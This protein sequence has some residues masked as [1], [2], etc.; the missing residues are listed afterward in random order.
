MAVIL[1]TLFKVGNNVFD[2]YYR[3]RFHILHTS[4][5][6]LYCCYFFLKNQR[7]YSW[8]G[9]F[10]NKSSKSIKID[11]LSLMEISLYCMLHNCTKQH[12]LER[13]HEDDVF[14][15]F[16]QKS[17]RVSFSY[18]ESSN[19]VSIGTSYGQSFQS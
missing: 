15:E 4:T 1:L 16:W 10:L 14:A 7:E 5:Y 8:I 17:Q 13:K 9:K 3:L 19:K 11:Y 2:P 6:R 18:F 12:I